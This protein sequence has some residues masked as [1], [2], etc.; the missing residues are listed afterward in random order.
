MALPQK[1][2]RLHP[3]ARAELQD[4]V[5]FYRTCGGEMLAV[6]FKHVVERGLRAIAEQPERY[7]PVRDFPQA[8]RIRLD[9]FPFSI[10]YVD[11]ESYIWVVAIAHGRRRPGYWTERLA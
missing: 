1:A 10:I 11:R 2:V 3:D 5:T 7:G 8:R 9:P 4:S 6:R